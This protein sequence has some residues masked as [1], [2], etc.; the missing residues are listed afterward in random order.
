MANNTDRERLAVVE[1]SYDKAAI[2]IN[3]LAAELVDL[4]GK[5]GE[6][7]KIV[8]DKAAQL[9]TLRALYDTSLEYINYLRD[10]NDS[11]Y[12]Q[13]LAEKLVAYQRRTS[14]P[15]TQIARL[16]GHPDPDAWAEADAWVDRLARMKEAINYHDDVNEVTDFLE[17]FKRNTQP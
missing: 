15:F 8:A 7:S 11:L 13:R 16:T 4:R 3:S 12:Q 14:L 10:L 17:E 9:A 5:F 2:I 1:R 6:R